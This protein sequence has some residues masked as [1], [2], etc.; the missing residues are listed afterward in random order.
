MSLYLQALIDG[1]LI[2]GVYATIA[3]GLS[4]SFGVMR[5]IN[6]A[7]GEL[8]MVSMYISYFILSRFNLDPYFVMI[9]TF[10]LMFGVGY[11]LQGTVLS[12]LLAKETAREPLSVLLFT[13]GLG[14]FLTNVVLSIAGAAPLTATTRYFGMMLNISNIFLSAP[15]IIS[16]VI[17]CISTITLYIVLQR[18]EIGRAIRA[19]AQDRRVA[20]LM[21][22]NQRKIYNL[23]L[24]ISIGLVGMAGALLIPF[25]SVST[26][27]GTTFSFKAFV[28]VVLG[29]KGSVLGALLGGFI[30]GIIEKIGGVIW[31]DSI[32]QM[33]VF[34]IFI[35]VLLFRPNGL[36]GEKDL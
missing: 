10:I 25:F 27:V 3:V 28:I 34:I 13:S 26:T 21:G 9:I 29:G 32:A 4:L 14:I 33:L 23:A 12:N 8:L 22:I 20:T 5:I 6:W 35:I 31:S 1:L 15:K 19:T 17:A 2:G 18:T 7:Q 36:M 24:G 16:F 30:V 11:L